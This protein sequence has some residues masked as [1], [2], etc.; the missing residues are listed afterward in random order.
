[1]FLIQETVVD[2]TIATT[3]FACDLE[4]C[5]GACCTL[6]GGRGAPLRDDEVDEIRAAFPAIRQYLNKE[7]LSVIERNGLVEG[8]P[9]DYSTTCINNRACVFVTY[10]NGI[11]RCSFEKAYLKGEIGWRKPISCHLFPIRVDGGEHQRLRYE[12]LSEC[13]PALERGES[14]GILLS[15][16]LEGA[17]TR[18]YGSTWYRQ[19][20]DGC[21]SVRQRNG[22]DFLKQRDA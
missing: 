22:S 15:D 19:F 20:S 14:E 7:H 8:R 11:A 3:K 13:V 18:E 4:R 10:E 1:M 21:Q 12:F 5:K 6:H 9:G 16:F 2:S 17:L